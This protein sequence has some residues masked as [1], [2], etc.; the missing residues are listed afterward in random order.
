MIIEGPTTTRDDGST[1]CIGIGV[2]SEGR[3]TGRFAIPQ[4]ADWD[5]PSATES[6]EFVDSM[7]ALPAVD[8]S[9][10]DQ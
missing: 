10:L 7:T 4:G 2:D 8:P 9:H 1:V 5:A 3:V 6:I